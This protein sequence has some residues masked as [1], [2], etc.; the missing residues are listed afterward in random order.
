MV[1]FLFIHKLWLINHLQMYLTIIMRKVSRPSADAMP[2]HCQTEK[3]LGI[4]PRSHLSRKC[5]KNFSRR[6]SKRVCRHLFLVTRCLCLLSRFTP[7]NWTENKLINCCSSKS[8]PTLYA[9]RGQINFWYLNMFD[10]K[11]NTSQ[12]HIN[13]NVL[14]C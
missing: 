9:K 2:F 11:N 5:W 8:N 1:I 3:T 12:E 10:N 4:A 7:P 13:E 14:D 6:S